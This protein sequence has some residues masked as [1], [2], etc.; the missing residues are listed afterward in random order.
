M[1]KNAVSGADVGNGGASFY[2]ILDTTSSLNGIKSIELSGDIDVNSPPNGS[3]RYNV[4]DIISSMSNVDTGVTVSM[5]TI[6][7]STTEYLITFPPSMGNVPLLTVNTTKLEPKS[8]ATVEVSSVRHGNVISGTFTLE[9]EEHVLGPLNYDISEDDMRIAIESL[10]QIESVVVKRSNP[11]SQHGYTWIIDFDSESNA[12]NLKNLKVK[13]DNLIATAVD[14]GAIN[15]VTITPTHGNEIGGTF[16]LS[17]R[18]AITSEDIAYDAQ[19]VDVK[20]ALENLSTIP[21]NSLAVSRAG[22]DLRRCYNWTIEFLVDEHYKL[23]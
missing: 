3:G 7:L 21:E 4:Q 1:V 10:P 2:V 15:S 9:Y 18:G 22:P 11:D 12:G 13:Q 19:A 16:K 20:E 14:A 17:Y 23:A 6:D 8:V 5:N